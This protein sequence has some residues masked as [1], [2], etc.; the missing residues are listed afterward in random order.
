MLIVVGNWADAVAIVHIVP[1]VELA[2]ASDV[3]LVSVGIVVEV[4][5]R[6]T[7]D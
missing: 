3:K 6:Q 1:A 7:L 2:G 4:G 5:R